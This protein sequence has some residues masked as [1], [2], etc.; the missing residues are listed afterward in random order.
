LLPWR[1]SEFLVAHV[2]ALHD[3]TLEYADQGLAGRLWN[4]V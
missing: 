4:Q 3:Y 2:G 1:R